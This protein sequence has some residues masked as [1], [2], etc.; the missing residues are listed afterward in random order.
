V[1]TPSTSR[2]ALQGDV[3]ARQ[4]EQLRARGIMLRV[5][6]L[7]VDPLRRTTS[8]ATEPGHVAAEQG[9]DGPKP[10]LRHGPDV[11]LRRR[12]GYSMHRGH[13]DEG[14]HPTDYPPEQSASVANAQASVFRV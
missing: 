1:P 6:D 4:R 9:A 12:D 11:A 8:I 14:L 2:A 5:N 13:K 7:G 10:N 3:D